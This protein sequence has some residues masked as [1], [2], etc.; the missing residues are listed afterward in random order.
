MGADKA[1]GPDGF[2]MGFYQE[3]WD[4]VKSDIM[5][6]VQ[7]FIQ[8]KVKMAKLN[9]AAVFL[10]PNKGNPQ[11]VKEYRPISLINCVYKII[12]KVLS[13]RLMPVI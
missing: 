12:T 3:C 8:G 13:N 11:T 7:G 1:P 2:S 9:Q 6:L 4:I 5:Q 10:I